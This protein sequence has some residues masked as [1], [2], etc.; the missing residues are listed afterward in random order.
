MISPG[1]FATEFGCSSINGGMDNRKLPRAQSPEEVADVII[2]AI[3]Q[4]QED[5]YT[6]GT[7]QGVIV[8]YFKD[9]TES[10]RILRE[11]GGLPSLIEKANH[12]R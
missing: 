1:V 2:E 4:R 8:E 12:S 9:I 7:Y 6:R 5:V 3:V 11:G 10:E